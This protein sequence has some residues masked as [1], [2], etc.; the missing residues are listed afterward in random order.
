MGYIVGPTLGALLFD[1]RITEHLEPFASNKDYLR[2]VSAGRRISVTIHR[3]GPDHAGHV[4]L[5]VHFDETRRAQ[6]E[7]GQK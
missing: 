5:G 1:V 4:V 7:Q 6:P 3:H 2:C